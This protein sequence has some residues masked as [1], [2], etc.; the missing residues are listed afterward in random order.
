[1]NQNREPIALDT[2][3]HISPSGQKRTL[4]YDRKLPFERLFHSQSC[5]RPERVVGVS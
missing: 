4:V 5:R 3:S 1:M 2:E